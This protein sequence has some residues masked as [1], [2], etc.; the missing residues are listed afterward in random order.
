MSGPL[1][2]CSRLGVGVALLCL[3]SCRPAADVPPALT[4][5]T[6][7][8]AP[9]GS[10]SGVLGQQLDLALG[11]MSFQRVQ[12][13]N[14]QGV[15]SIEAGQADLAISTADEPYLHYLAAQENP[16]PGARQLRA[17]AA[18]QLVPVH[19]VAGRET[20]IS[21]IR[22]LREQHA[23]IGNQP[24]IPLLLNAF[25]IDVAAVRKPLADVDTA[26]ALSTGAV[27]AA[28]VVSNFPFEPVAEAAREGARLLSLD[29]PVI[30]S[31]LAQNLFLRRT[32]IPAGTYAGQ[33]SDVRTVGMDVVLVTHVHLQETVAYDITRALFD[34]LPT[35]VK[36]FPALNRMDAQWAAATPIPLHP[37]AAR[38]FR[39]WELRR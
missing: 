31:L 28:L 37:G 36:T 19:F 2:L 10:F 34:V 35:L 15:G 13:D 9:A 23:W 26:H 24:V 30:D 29:D 11:G 27:R 18:L 14:A 1:R 22:D 38:F 5:L 12:A 39:E 20:S 25:G 21:S 32:V 8:A 16:R 33:T 17:I 6:F 3:A 7:A 4:T